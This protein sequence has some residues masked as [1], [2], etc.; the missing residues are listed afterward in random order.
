MRNKKITSVVC[1]VLAAL[2]IMSL[3]ASAIG[4]MTA[5]GVSQ[6][7]IDAL[8]Q[9]KNDLKNQKDQVGVQLAGLQNEQAA[10]LEQKAAL[11]EQNELA[12][13]E[14]DL[15]NEQIAIYDG[16]IAD[17]EVE[18][19][20]ARLLEE[21]QKEKFRS[22]MRA[23]E[24][25]GTMDYVSFIFQASSF[26]ELLT[27]VDNISEVLESDKALEAQYI[28]AREN[29]EVVKSE[30]EAIQADQLIKRAELEE[31]KA[32]LELEIADAAKLIAELEEDIEEYKRQFAANEAAE[33]QVQAEI[34]EMTKQFNKQQEELKQQGQ[35]VVSGSG[36][37]SWPT[38]GSNV[39]TS[40]FGWR[41]HPIFQTEKYHSG[42]DIAAYAG[43]P[44]Y[45]SD[46]GTVQTAVYSSSYGNYV[47]INHGNGYTTLYAHQSSMAVSAGQTVSKGQVIG[48]VGSTGWS[49]GPHLHFEISYNGARVDPA[50]YFG[51]IVFQD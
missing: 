48:Y 30:Y 14:I 42:V 39:V 23:M 27:R 1:L 43:T 20:E 36:S 25:N 15:I 6:S 29:V 9:K 41:I 34:D 24:E 10:V 47:V 2:M 50:G 33:W 28:A 3:F 45:A 12:R 11:D 44:I 18:L 51:N 40:R 5:Y 13:Q 21:A 22:R 7:E 37:F 19:D 26:A 49:T 17:K 35:T 16:L 32:K 31:S 4:S 46:G 8:E 38:P